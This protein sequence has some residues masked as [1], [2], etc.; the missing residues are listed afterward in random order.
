MFKVD[1]Y[2]G[3][4]T[5][6]GVYMMTLAYSDTNGNEGE[7]EVSITVLDTEDDEPITVDPGND[8]WSGIV[9]TYDSVVELGY[10]KSLSSCRFRISIINSYFWWICIIR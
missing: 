10:N 8:L 7:H 1:N 9:K 5:V 4:E 6:P 3:N 2:T